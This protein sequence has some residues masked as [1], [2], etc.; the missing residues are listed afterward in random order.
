MSL[1]YVFGTIMGSGDTACNVL[2][3]AET[4]GYNN[5]VSLCKQPPYYMYSMR[6]N[7]V[8]IFGK[9]PTEYN[10]NFF[11]VISM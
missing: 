1:K 9:T 7:H 6:Y 10:I 8:I 4:L 2:V 11:V 3:C 5:T